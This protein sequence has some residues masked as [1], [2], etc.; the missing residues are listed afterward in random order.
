MVTNTIAGSK[1]SPRFDDNKDILYWFVG[2][3]FEIKWTLH[4]VEEDGSDSDDEVDPVIYDP[5]D[6]II[7]GF[8]DAKK[9]PVYQFTFTDIQDD[10][11]TTVFTPAISK[12]FVAGTYT[13]CIKYVWTD[14]DGLSRIQTIVDNKRVRVEECH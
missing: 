10:T 1:E 2:D 12:K 13:Y 4:L 6:Q 3:A 9:N 11:V 7:I 5:E 8:F 14:D